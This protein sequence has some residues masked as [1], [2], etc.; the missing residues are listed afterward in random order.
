VADRPAGSAHLLR[1]RLPRRTVRARLALF[2]FA[3]FLLS[4]AVLLAATVGLW[5]GGSTVRA[6][7][8]A[9]APRPALGSR[10]PV[11][12]TPP[13]AAQHTSDLHQLLIASGIALA[14]MAALSVL[15]GWLV[16]GRFLAPLRAMTTATRK[17][18]ASN[19]HERLNLAG[20]DDEIKELGDTFDDLL[21]RLER[22]FDFERQFVANA[23]HELRTPLTTMRASLDVSMAKPEPVPAQTQVLADRLRRELDQVDRLLESFLTLSQAQQ[24]PPLDDATISLDAAVATAV[25]RCSSSIA[26]MGLSVDQERCGPTWARGSEML[27]SRMVEN[28]IDNAVQHNERGGWLRVETTIEGSQVRLVVENGG[29]VLSQDEVGQLAR[30]FRRLGS[31]R[32]GSGKGSG[33]GLSIVRS[34]ADAH[35]GALDLQAR[36]GG[37]LRVVIILPLG[38]TDRGPA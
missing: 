26:L 4:G 37:G 14:L 28:V 22:S 34:I 11:R 24:G 19:L 35:G 17:I 30:P 16:A 32:T 12:A 9:A 27:L 23:S 20:P 33:L 6:T 2:Y 7:A 15:L 13:Q 10:L 21:G 38:A 8:V 3:F 5:Q 25:E 18:S 29:P 1:L 31:E 36:A